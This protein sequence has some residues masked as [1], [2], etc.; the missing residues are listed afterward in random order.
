MAEW[1]DGD[2]ETRLG[3]ASQSRDHGMVQ[4]A[5]AGG[6]GKCKDGI[7][8][9]R[10]CKSFSASVG[11]E[12]EWTLVGHLLES[13][14]STVRLDS[15]ARCTCQSSAEA[16]GMGQSEATTSWASPTPSRL[17]R[18][19]P[20]DTFLER[21]HQ[22]SPSRLDFNQR[23]PETRLSSPSSSAHG[24]RR[25]RQSA[26]ESPALFSICTSTYLVHPYVHTPHGAVGSRVDGRAAD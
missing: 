8:W 1:Q 19:P 13:S 4:A 20:T 23:R 5:R 11:F 21:P 26:Q 17:S 7:S 16:A 2:M 14:A 15:A 18:L 12:P 22:S 25:H 10:P 24:Q 6:R 9:A 3:G